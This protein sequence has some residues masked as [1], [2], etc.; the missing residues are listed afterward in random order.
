MLYK[1]Y[2]NKDHE[3][4]QQEAMYTLTNPSNMQ[5]HNNKH[6]GIRARQVWEYTYISFHD[7]VLE[8]ARTGTLD[9]ENVLQTEGVRI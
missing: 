5:T 9:F 1:N 6:A 7:R 4:E 2:K 8:K 3:R